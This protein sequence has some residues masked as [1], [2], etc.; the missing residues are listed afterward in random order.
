[1]DNLI[2]QKFGGTSV[3]TVEKIKR[4]ARRIVGEAQKGKRM[5]VGLIGPQRM[6][7][8]GAIILLEGLLPHLT[9]TDNDEP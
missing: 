5:V 4:V 8:E 1:M 7:Y 6:D 2:V 9:G 3:G